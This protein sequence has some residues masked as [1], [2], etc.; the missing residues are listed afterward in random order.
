M[1]RR[2]S[3][4][5]LAI[6]ALAPVARADYAVLRSGQRLHITGYERLGASVRLQIA[7][8]SVEV[9]AADLISVEPEE[10]FPAP[11]A[12]TMRLPF[13]DLIRAAAL[14][15]GVD[16]DLIAAVIAAESNFDPKAVS[17]KFARGLMQILPETASRFGVT[18]V[19]DPSQNIDAGTRYLKE[20]LARYKEDLALTLAAY[21]AG[22]ERVEQYRG[23]PPF[24]ETRNYVSRV[25]RNLKSRK[26]P[27][28]ST[29]GAAVHSKTAMR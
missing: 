12:A 20:L 4:A 8:G 24:P 3:I 25:T 6:A 29:Q 27:K 16:A 22:P 23:V 11:P 18:D 2:L 13:S 19:F 21:N 28:G 17:A 26:N 14:K 10:V 15:H 1:I 9:A 5:L 7:G